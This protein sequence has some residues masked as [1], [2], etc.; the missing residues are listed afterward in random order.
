[1]N[2]ELMVQNELSVADVQKQVQLIQTLMHKVMKDEEHYGTI[3]GTQKPTLLKAGAE[4]IAFTFR[5]SREI[6]TTREDLGN[7]HREYQSVVRLT[8]IPT[9]T[10]IGE[11][12]GM[13]ST[14]EAKYR[15]RSQGGFEILDEP[16]PDD[17]RQKKQEYRKRGFGVRQVD[18]QWVW[19][20]FG[21]AEKVENPDIADT[22]NT[23]LKMS[24]KRAFVDAILS[25][26]AASDIFSQDLED[27]PDIVEE[28]PHPAAHASPRK[29]K[30]Q[31]PA[32]DSEEM[33][34]LKSKLWKAADDMA[35][36]ELLTE[37]QHES[38]RETIKRS[39]SEKA[40]QAM[41]DNYNRQLDARDNQEPP[42]EGD[43]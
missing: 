28:Q 16:I 5:F 33:K 29:Q 4:K 40:L 2:T 38:A 32:Q 23:V 34:E 15:Y 7:G 19:V 26:T 8:H 31:Q 14:M 42:E 12:V 1:M 24:V 39:T 25:A 11:G 3:P 43:Y 37:K 20:K 27:N 21:Q 35:A 41:L 17:Y 22:F 18:G 9:G 10:Y 36:A 30:K 13:C 6:T